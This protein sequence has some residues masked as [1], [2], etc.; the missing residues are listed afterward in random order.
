[1]NIEVDGKTFGGVEPVDST[2]PASYINVSEITKYD[3]KDVNSYN[4]LLKQNPE[5]VKIPKKLN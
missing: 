3:M 2:N 4:L 5:E 1:M